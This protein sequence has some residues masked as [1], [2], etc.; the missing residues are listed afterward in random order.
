[1]AEQTPSQAI[2]AKKSVTVKD[3]RG[4]SIEVRKLRTLERM[5][6]VE[7]VGA[8]NA[9][10]EQYLGFAVLAYSVS[11]IDGNPMGRPVTK[12][13]LEAIVQELDDDG[14]DAVGNAF[15][16]HFLEQSLSEAEAKASVKNG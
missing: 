6:L 4:R 1:M 14:F 13:A 10:N 2:I 15:T 3:K 5:Q 12:L 8:A 16:D 11:S 9:A 7:L